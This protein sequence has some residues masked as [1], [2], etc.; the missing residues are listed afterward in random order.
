MQPM[1]AARAA[2]LSLPAKDPLLEAI[3]RI[4]EEQRDY[5]PPISWFARFITCCLAPMRRSLTLP[6]RARGM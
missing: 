3:L 2:K 1:T 4:V 5:W 6:S